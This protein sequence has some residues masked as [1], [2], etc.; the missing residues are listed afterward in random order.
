M[1]DIK[2]NDREILDNLHRLAGLMRDM[3][4]V[5]TDIG[6]YM[7][8]ATKR[9]FAEGK[10]P[11]GRRW[12]GNRPVTLQEYLRRKGGA[13][14]VRK[15]EKFQNP[16]LKKDGSLNKRGATQLANKRVLVGESKRLG[17]EIHYRADGRSIVVGSS[18]IYSATQQFGARRGAFGRTKRGAPIPW[19]DIPA[20]P[21]LGVSDDDRR[22]IL[23]IIEEHLEA[24][25]GG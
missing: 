21:F 19:G 11:D 20:R 17:N 12:A 2:I 25:A 10:G 8:E 1:I 16:Y 3:R 13:T 24:A 5:M 15:G 7:I 9:R 4:P 6:E 18:L 22:N 14:V 23:D